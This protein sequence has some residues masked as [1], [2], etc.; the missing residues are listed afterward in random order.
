MST[1][2]LWI[3][4]RS[5]VLA[6]SR[7]RQVDGRRRSF[8]NCSLLNNRRSNV[9]IPSIKT[10]TNESIASVTST[11]LLT[12]AGYIEMSSSGVYSLFPLGLKVRRK[13]E[14][15]IRKNVNQVGGSELALPLVLSAEPWAKTGRANTPEIF[16]LQDMPGYLLAPTHEEEI[17]SIVASKAISFRD[18]PLRLYQIGEKFRKELRPRGGMMRGRQFTMFDLYS[19]DSSVKD[20]MR[21]YRDMKHAYSQ[22][23]DD[24]GVKYVVADADSGEIGGDLSH[25][26]HYLTKVGQDTIVSCSACEYTANVEVALSFPAENSPELTG[27]DVTV[28]YGLLSKETLLI[29]YYPSNRKLNKRIVKRRFPEYQLDHPDPVSAIVDS[30]IDPMI[31]SLIRV[32]DER[33]PEGLSLPDLPFQVNISNITNVRMP[34]VEVEPTEFPGEGCPDCEDGVL[35]S[36]TAAEVGHTFYLGQKYSKPLAATAKAEDNSVVPYEMGCYGI[37]VTRLIDVIAEVTRDENGLCWPVSVAP[38][39]VIIVGVDQNETVMTNIEKR[40]QDS[41]IDVLVDDRVNRKLGWKMYEAK[42]IG[43]PVMVI[44]GN[45]YLKSGK[46]E[47]ENRRTKEKFVSELCET[48]ELVKSILEAEMEAMR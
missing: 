7:R 17:T 42:K 27:D 5:Q 29:F 8:H 22:I 38:Y 33:V 20:A 23:F 16:T 1:R 48:E 18:L 37:G 14:A 26:Y 28:E 47:V 19:F 25:E 40:L 44:V 15:I 41:G 35:T 36:A 4:L 31:R 3:E 11:G 43:I 9:F 2:R 46:V 13:L 34:C 24:I 6:L 39:E 12:M 21:S 30:D 32:F 45:S 10:D